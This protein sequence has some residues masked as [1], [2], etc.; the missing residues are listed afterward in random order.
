MLTPAMFG[1]SRTFFVEFPMAAAI[2]ATVYFCLTA[3]KLPFY[4]STPLI[5]VSAAATM[6]LK[7]TFPIFLALPVLIIVLWRLYHAVVK[8][9]EPH[10]V[11]L[12]KTLFGLA[13]ALTL[14]ATWYVPNLNYWLT[15]MMQNVAGARGGTYGAPA[16]D[17]LIDEAR[18][19]FLSYHVLALLLLLVLSAAT[20]IISLIIGRECEASR[21]V[22]ESKPPGEAQPWAAVPQ[23]KRDDTAFIAILAAAA[24]FI[25]ALYVCLNAA[26]KDVRILFPALPALAIFIAMG[27]HAM[28]RG[29][30]VVPAAALLLFPLVAFFNLSFTGA[31]DATVDWRDP[32]KADIMSIDYMLG[33]KPLKPYVYPPNSADWK[34]N[35]IVEA[36]NRSVPFPLEASIKRN[37][38]MGVGITVIPNSPYLQP[39]WLSYIAARDFVEKKTSYQ[40]SFADPGYHDPSLMPAACAQALGADATPDAVFRE[41]LRK[42]ADEVLSKSQYILVTEGGWQGPSLYDYTVD[43]KIL[44]TQGDVMQKIT[45]IM[46]KARLFE[47]L[48]GDIVLPDGS[49]V[50]IYRH[51]YAGTIAPQQELADFV[52]LFARAGK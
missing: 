43:G 6:L 13:I 24:W 27:Y 48:R 5:A 4:A 10:L 41:L 36:V 44:F 21:P 25:G 17:Y 18:M 1:L 12:L 37:S 33:R 45:E 35:E 30:R 47:R 32:V 52:N 3:H 15:F 26:D 11:A 14:A 23:E 31:Y 2:A 38:A 39:N 7:V 51:K 28:G 9:S 34:A 42:Y 29:W 46:P 49:R 20:W 19:S 16:A 50:I 8:G 22:S 40:M